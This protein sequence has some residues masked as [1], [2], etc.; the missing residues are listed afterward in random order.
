MSSATRTDR[1]RAAASGA[2]AGIAAYLL[3]YLVTYATQRGQVEEQLRAF[4]ALTE[5]FG[6]DPL[7]A[8]QAVGWLFYNAH[9]VATEIPAPL[10]GTRV[11]NF[12]AETDG[13]SLSLLYAVPPVLLLVAGLVVARVA[14]ARE[15]AAGAASGALVVVGYLPLAAIGTF[16]FRY[17]VG[18]GAVAPV[19]VTALLAGIVYPV[20][21]GAIGGAAAVLRD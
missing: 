6:G 14:G 4:N 1:V 16:L 20:V 3:G 11:V 15:P 18:E 17:S 13:G 8:W 7:P 10:G 21:A 19:L 9:A 5:L 12:I 2:V